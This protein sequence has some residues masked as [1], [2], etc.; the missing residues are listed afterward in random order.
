M[1]RSKEEREA[2]I[3]EHFEELASDTSELASEIKCSQTQY[4]E[5]L[6]AI[7]QRLTEDKN[8]ALETLDSGL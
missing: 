5:G 3:M 2:E 7:I 6:E 1:A 8:V 4:V